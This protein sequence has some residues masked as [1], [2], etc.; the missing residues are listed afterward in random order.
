MG[1]EYGWRHAQKRWS[2]EFEDFE[3]ESVESWIWAVE[4]VVGFFRNSTDSDLK[5]H[6]MRRA[7]G[8][9]SIVRILSLSLRIAMGRRQE[10]NKDTAE[11][12]TLAYLSYGFLMV[13]LFPF[14]HAPFP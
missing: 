7:L 5:N 3:K 1:L 8:M 13:S 2:W 6:K 10:I 9:V 12:T 11:Y 14:Y 4:D